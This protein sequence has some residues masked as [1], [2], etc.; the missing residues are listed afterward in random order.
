MTLK[1]ILSILVLSLPSSLLAGGGAKSYTNLFP[2]HLPQTELAQT[3]AQPQLIEPAFMARPKAGT[4][5]LKW[6]DAERADHYHLQ[7][8]T[9]PNFKWLVVDQNMIQAT[10]FDLTAL[11]PNTHYYWRV[12]AIK[13]NNLPGHRKAAFVKSSFQTN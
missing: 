7:V 11:E 10:S 8:A 13:S 9:D 6:T 1:N 3:P 2:P 5:S 12:A 4:L